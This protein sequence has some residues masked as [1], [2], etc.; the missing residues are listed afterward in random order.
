MV[1]FAL[2]LRTLLRVHRGR[3]MV[4]RMNPSMAGRTNGT[5]LSNPVAMVN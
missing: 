1:K 3:F 4:L 2:L 5:D